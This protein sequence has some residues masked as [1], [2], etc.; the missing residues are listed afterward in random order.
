[1]VL[2]GGGAGCRG[3]RGHW[4]RRRNTGSQG[5]RA[6]GLS[7]APR[8]AAVQWHDDDWGLAGG[9]RVAMGEGIGASGGL[10]RENEI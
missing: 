2:G 1:V 8:A 9:L 7:G 5:S 4:W 10:E 3:V 6:P